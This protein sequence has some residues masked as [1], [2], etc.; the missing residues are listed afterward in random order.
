MILGAVKRHLV[1]F[2]VERVHATGA[3]TQCMPGKKAHIGTV[4]FENVGRATELGTIL[5]RCQD[6]CT[7]SA[8]L[9][10]TL[11]GAGSTCATTTDN[12]RPISFRSLSGIPGVR[13]L[14]P[15]TIDSAA[16]ESSPITGIWRPP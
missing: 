9:R 2:E 3:C 13:K 16:T 6:A 11:H 1:V 15:S 5:K 14:H 4:A 10:S 12:L 8:R 7:S